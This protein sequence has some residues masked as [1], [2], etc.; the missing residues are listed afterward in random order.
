MEMAEKKYMLIVKS[1]TKISE[2]FPDGCNVWKRLNAWKKP[3][4]LL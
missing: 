3:I 4:R 1:M 2:A